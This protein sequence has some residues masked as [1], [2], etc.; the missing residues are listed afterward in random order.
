[1]TA[2]S[3]SLEY[4]FAHL[5]F[6]DVDV[7]AECGFGD[8]LEPNE[9]RPERVQPH[10][11]RAGRGVLVSAGTERSFFDLIFSSEEKCEGLVVRDINP[12]VKAYV[13]FNTLMLR[14]SDSR[15]EYATLSGQ[16]PSGLDD[17]D[18]IERISTL[19][20]KI[21]KHDMP[22]KVKEYYLKHLRDFAF[23]Y[24]NAPLNISQR[25]RNICSEFFDKCRYDIDDS[26]FSKLQ[27]YARAGNI[28]STI[29]SI[30]DLTFLA[31]RVVSVVDTSNIGGYEF[32]DLKVQG[33]PRVI[34]VEPGCYFS[35]KHVPLTDAE[36]G[37]FE[38]HLK[39]LRRVYGKNCFHHIREKSCILRGKNCLHQLLRVPP[40]RQS[41]FNDYR[42]NVYSRG[43]LR[44]LRKNVV[45]LT[46]NHQHRHAKR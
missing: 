18:I 6:S 1:M 20:E 14:V 28:V 17:D 10:L 8:F 44:L 25:W 4:Q 31:D 37:E 45:N 21:G 23:V 40:S 5:A 9:L 12:K 26:Q 7:N 30:N 2:V 3:P 41:V 11:D 33:N 24:F 16:K 19:R 46:G 35:H 43:T 32:I 42:W 36:R 39:K 15:K 27:R 13:D 38:G 29:G 34:R 22:Q